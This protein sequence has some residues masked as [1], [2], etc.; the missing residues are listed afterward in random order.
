MMRLALA[1][2]LIGPTMAALSLLVL[3]ACIGGGGS[4]GQVPV[5][6]P[7]GSIGAASASPRVD[8]VVAAIND[9]RIANGLAPLTGNAALDQAAQRHA[10]D[11]AASG[12][13]GHT[14]SDGSSMEDR[15][16]G[17]GYSYRSLGENVA[18]GQAGA[19]EVV[20]DWMDSPGHRA[21]I[22]MAEA[23]EIGVGFA[24]GAAVG[25][26]PGRFWVLVV[27]AR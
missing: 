9:R 6:S 27:G 3:A 12:R 15:V 23:R 4:A 25:N 13:L 18:V 17:A 26:M 8:A 19:A 22:L 2:G 14:G 16:R 5:V 24:E 20:A 1:R 10:A 21:N 7:G 11:M